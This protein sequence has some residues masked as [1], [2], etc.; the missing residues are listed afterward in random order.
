MRRFQCFCGHEIFFENEKCL[1]CERK[2]GFAINQLQM[3]ALEETPEAILRVCGEPGSPPWR[4]CDNYLQYHT[5]NWV[6]PQ[7]DTQT[8]CD[9]C[10][11]NQTIP[12][13]TVAG[14]IALWGRIEVAKRR[15]LYSLRWLGLEL[16]DNGDSTQPGLRF[17][18]LADTP[19]QHVITGHNEGLITLSIA[20]ADDAERAR[21]RESL[22]E[23]YRTLLGH[24]R[25]ESGHYYWGTL[26][27]KTAFHDRFRALFGDETIDYASAVARHYQEGPPEDWATSFISAYATSHPFEDWAESWA[28]YLHIR[29]TLQSA[30]AYGFGVAADLSDS[31]RDCS[32]DFA[33]VVAEWVP[34][35]LALNALNRSM[36]QPDIYPFALPP[37]SIAKLQFVHEVVLAA[38]GPSVAPPPEKR[39]TRSRKRNPG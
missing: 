39:N 26:I 17:A 28:H 36:G 12:D 24:L 30:R 8:L 5:C 25:H 4:A 16:G 11:L 14:N 27:D 20:E 9:S 37:P 34:F 10:K 23:P 3:V 18:L 1:S 13:L 19:Q 21:V 7:N 29:D 22:G 32:R 31:S 35:T 33:S 2:V 38:H 6:F 15:L